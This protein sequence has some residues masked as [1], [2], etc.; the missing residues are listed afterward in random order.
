MREGKKERTG[1]VRNPFGIHH[2]NI[3]ITHMH[4]STRNKLRCTGRFQFTWSIKF[5]CVPQFIIRH[6]HTP[7][8]FSSRILLYPSISA[9]LGALN[10]V[11][12]ARRENEAKRKNSK[13]RPG[14]TSKQD[15]CFLNVVQSPWL[16]LL[17]ARLR[18]WPL[19]RLLL[20][21]LSSHSAL[22]LQRS[23][24]SGGAGCR[25]V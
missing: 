19:Q 23:V 25:R 14:E 24:S 22:H 4:T 11:F 15:V 16:S 9:S 20:S 8:F 2:F 3:L 1:F 18:L 6:T 12:T 5:S 10:P 7:V 21:A 13:Q 17:R